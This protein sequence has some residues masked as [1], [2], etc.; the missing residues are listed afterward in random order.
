L[1]SRPLTS[2]IALQDKMPSLTGSNH[3]R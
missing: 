2:V 1:F 3:C